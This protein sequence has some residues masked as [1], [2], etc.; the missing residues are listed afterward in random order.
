[1]RGR[2]RGRAEVFRYINTQK[3]CTLR[4]SSTSRIFS[5]I[6]S[7][8]GRLCILSAFRDSSRAGGL[9]LTPSLSSSW[10]THTHTHTHRG[11]QST[12]NHNAA[13]DW[14]FTETDWP[15]RD[16]IATQINVLYKSALN[17]FVRIF[18]FYFPDVCSFTTALC[19]SHWPTES[20]TNAHVFFSLQ[21][22]IFFFFLT[23]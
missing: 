8:L 2:G 14:T 7:L 18:P 23:F 10:Q 16:N 17:E 3:H 22:T 9:R 11:R 12:D 5:S 15:V 21:N 19:V 4:L 1:M 20:E 6:F 13:G